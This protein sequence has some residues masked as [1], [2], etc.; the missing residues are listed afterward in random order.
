MVILLSFHLRFTIMAYCWALLPAE[1]PTFAQ[2][3]S[4]LSE[5][6]SQITRYV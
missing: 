5:F 1:R 4:C 2:L 6:Y 3:Q